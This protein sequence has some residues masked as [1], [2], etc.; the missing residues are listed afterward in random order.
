MK[1]TH[2]LQIRISP[3][4]DRALETLARRR[5]LRGGKRSDVAREAICALIERELPMEGK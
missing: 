3:A 1:L 5:R 4:M 2:T